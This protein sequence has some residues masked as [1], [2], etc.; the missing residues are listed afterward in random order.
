MSASA[1]A[2]VGNWL[3][4]EPPRT[5]GHSVAER[6]SAREEEEERWDVCKRK[7]NWN[8][9]RVNGYEEWWTVDCGRP[10]PS[11]CTNRHVIEGK[12]RRDGYG[13]G[14]DDDDEDDDDDSGGTGSNRS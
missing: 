14:G 1:S 11:T 8:Q 2:K 4:A 13:G 9:I 7:N 6:L 3:S 5:S 10:L 12:N